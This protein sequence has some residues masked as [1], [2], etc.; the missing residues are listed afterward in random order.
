MNDIDKLL[1]KISRK[2]RVMLRHLIENLL[3]DN[4]DIEVNKLKG[5][6]FYKVRKG[7]FRI[8]LHYDSCKNIIIDSVRLR[9][10][11]TYKDF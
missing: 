10:E 9:Q 2:D 6:D 7:N 1:K 5:S 8:I 4:K 11:N 3:N